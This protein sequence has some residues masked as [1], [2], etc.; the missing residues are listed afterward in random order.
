[1]IEIKDAVKTPHGYVGE[2]KQLDNEN[3][4]QYAL[5]RRICSQSKRWFRV[6]SLKFLWHSS[7]GR[8]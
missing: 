5:V 3:G 2:V 8:K 7:V 6:D 4:V 1:M